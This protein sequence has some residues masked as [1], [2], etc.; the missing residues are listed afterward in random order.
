LNITQWRFKGAARFGAEDGKK[1][2]GGGGTSL[3]PTIPKGI[4]DGHGKG[5]NAS[6][7]VNVASHEGKCGAGITVA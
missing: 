4:R 2:P 3:S 1:A 5:R 6:Q 7:P